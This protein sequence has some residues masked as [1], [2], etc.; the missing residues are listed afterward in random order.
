VER[1][2]VSRLLQLDPVAGWELWRPLENYPRRWEQSCY[3]SVGHDSWVGWQGTASGSQSADKFEVIVVGAAVV[4][5]MTKPHVRA[6]M[7]R[8]CSSA[9]RAL[10]A[11]LAVGVVSLSLLTEGLRQQG[12][13]GDSGPL[14]LETKEGRR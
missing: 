3:Q 12:P 7:P 2:C 4:C 13:C 1:E 9:G 8:E 14:E 11:L 6:L 10:V 5:A